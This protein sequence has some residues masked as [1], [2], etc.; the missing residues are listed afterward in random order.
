MSIPI[1]A[2][3]WSPGQAPIRSAVM[4]INPALIRETQAVLRTALSTH[5]GPAINRYLIPEGYYE[6]YRGRFP[7]NV[8]P[9]AF[10]Y[11]DE[12][13]IS[14]ELERMGW[15]LPT[16][17]DSNSTNCQLNAFANHRH[18]ERH[19]FH[20]YVLEIAN[21]VRQGVMTRVDGIEKIYGEQ[22]RKRVAY[23]KSKLEL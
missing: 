7:Y 4:K 17:T 20:P 13:K 2:F 15:K 9:L 3:G 12:K 18:I 1:V 11:Y 14:S 6:S 19:G 22:D 16:D 21:M 23:G 8:H 10:F 5:V